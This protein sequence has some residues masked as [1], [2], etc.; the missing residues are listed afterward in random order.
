[1]PLLTLQFTYMESGREERGKGLVGLV[2]GGWGKRSAILSLLENYIAMPYQWLE[3]M[4]KV[5]IGVCSV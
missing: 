1:M 2:K 3:V 5:F 4:R